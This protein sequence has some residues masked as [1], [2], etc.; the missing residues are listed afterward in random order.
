KVRGQRVEPADVEIV[1]RE[2]PAVANV[3]VIGVADAN[4]GALL[5][6]YVVPRGTEPAAGELREFVRQRLP[7]VMVPSYL[8]FLPALPLLP[9][10]KVDRARLSAPAR[11]RPDTGVPFVP[12]ATAAERR[13]AGL[14]AGVL[15]LDA[16][17]MDDDFFALGG[18]SLR[19]ILLRGAVEL[20]TDVEI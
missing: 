15:G 19:L 2:H 9:S 6:A 8:A 18:D 17:G 3:V 16:V 11:T 14:V 12:P 20:A 4:Q 1:L 5:A 13:V 7:E 10:G